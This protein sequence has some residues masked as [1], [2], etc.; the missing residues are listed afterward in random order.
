MIIDGFLYIAVLVF[1]AAVLIYMP[2]IIKNKRAQMVFN[3]AP[4]V[5]LIYLT[6]MILCTVNAWDLEKTAGTYSALKNPLLYAMLFL[7]LLR[8]DLRKIVKLFTTH[9]NY[10]RLL[11]LRRKFFC[12][13]SMYGISICPPALPGRL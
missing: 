8:C 9:C 10:S 1:V 6:L 7:M 5:V 12:C 11:I 2:Q 3:F 4:P 13:P